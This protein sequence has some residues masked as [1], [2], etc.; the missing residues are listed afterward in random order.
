VSLA[1]SSTRV[2]GQDGA[3]LELAA[4]SPPQSAAYDIVL[5]VHILVAIGAVVTLVSS[6]VAAAAI[7]KVAPGSPWPSSAVRYFRPGPDVVGR[8]IY[9]IPITGFALLGLSQHAYSLATSFV[10]I[11]LVLW[12]VA[13]VVAEAF[14][15]RPAGRV[16]KVVASSATAPNDEQWRRQLPVMRWSIDVVLLLVVAGA[17]VMLVQ[18]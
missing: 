10:G 17:V 18:P 14:V 2:R 13:A 16:A 15:F 11:G 3:V 8:V 6:Y 9:L 1:H 4:T 12:V 7:G 5:L